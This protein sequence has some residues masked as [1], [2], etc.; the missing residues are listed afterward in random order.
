MKVNR[1]IVQVTSKR[2]PVLV[3]AGHSYLAKP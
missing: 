1:G 3:R 2:K